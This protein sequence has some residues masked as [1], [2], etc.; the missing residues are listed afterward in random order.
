MAASVKI[1]RTHRGQKTFCYSITHAI[2]LVII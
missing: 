1:R 2:D